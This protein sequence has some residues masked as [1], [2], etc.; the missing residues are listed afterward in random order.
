MNTFEELGI[1]PQ[2]IKAVTDLGFESPLPVQQEVI[3]SIIST[4]R[5]IIGLSQTG[6][7]KTAAYGLPVL[8]MI[9]EQQK[10]PQILVL[11]PTRELCIQ[12]FNDFVDYTRHMPAL[13]IVAVYGGSSIEQQV[14]LLKAG[15]QVIIATPGR[16]NDLIRQK[17]VNLKAIQFLILDEADEMLNMGFREELNSI[18]ELLPETRRTFL[19][20]ATMPNE[21]ASL[22]GNYMNDP[23]EIVVGTKN[24]GAENVR[25]HFY[26]VHAHDRYLALKRVVDFYPEIYGII[27][28]RTRAE[29]KDVAEKL[30]KDGYNADAL[31]GD[32]S[33]AQRDYVM[34]R[35]RLRNLRILVAT[36]VAARGLDVDDLTHVVNFNLPDDDEIYTH[37]SGR[38]GRVNKR[39]LSVSILHSRDRGRISRIE[40]LIG[41]KFD[42]KP[43]P[44]G[45]EICEKQLFSLVD[46]MENVEVNES[47]IADYLPVVFK[48][49]SLMSREDLITR[50][51]SVEFNRFLD[52]YK[53]A[54]DL[55]VNLKYDK[56]QDRKSRKKVSFAKF[57]INLGRM[58]NLMPARLLG[59]V[60]DFT[61]TRNITIGKTI[62]KDSYSIFEADSEY[63]DLIM[64]SFKGRTHEN[65]QL[66]VERLTDYQ[67][68]DRRE[69]RPYG[70][71]T[72]DRKPYGS[73]SH[74][75]KPYGSDSRP[76]KYGDSD[77]RP[78][79]A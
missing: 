28:C 53:D 23:L 5:D 46:K 57:K 27:F 37:R 14:R 51:V 76:K 12:I 9:D 52:Y 77:A 49:L 41:K 78:K 70:K 68:D 34:Q 56:D 72:F 6:S 35:F 48:K 19:F 69:S 61:R 66:S 79:R 3:P 42:Y 2:I 7:G 44:S 38:T 1:H 26:V 13:Q 10:L 25:H 65:R 29:T 62:I 18:L 59:I 75:R 55:N 63:A 43:V 73:D 24:A 47:E 17:K 50:F 16:I 40:K 32:L 60:N 33:Q 67:D 36:D 74:K 21:V 31:H 39:G 64:S 71:K 15:A 45:K 8:T 54:T 20:S 58:D 11:S 30:M 22:V 4:D